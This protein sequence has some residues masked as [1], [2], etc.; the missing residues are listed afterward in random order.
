[1][2]QVHLSTCGEGKSFPNADY[3]SDFFNLPRNLSPARFL[4]L[5]LLCMLWIYTFFH[6]PPGIHRP[7]GK[8]ISLPFTQLHRRCASAL[9]AGGVTDPGRHPIH[10]AHKLPG[11]SEQVTDNSST[12]QPPAAHLT[13]HTPQWYHITLHHSRGNIC[14]AMQGSWDESFLRLKLFTLGRMRWCGGHAT[15]RI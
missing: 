3:F 10:C 2:P 9:G 1:M 15:H 13:L 7:E 12:A 4:E 11:P 8:K 6:T 5:A 14:K